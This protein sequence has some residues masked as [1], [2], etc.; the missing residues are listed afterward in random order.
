ML[1]TRYILAICV[2]VFW[3]VVRLFLM[4]RRKVLFQRW[5]EREEADAREEKPVDVKPEEPRT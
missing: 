3:I 1:E 5:R 2:L 4:H